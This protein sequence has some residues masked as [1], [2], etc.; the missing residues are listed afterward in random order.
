MKHFIDRIT[1][2][3]SSY[4][5]LVLASASTTFAGSMAWVSYARYGPDQFDMSFREVEGL[6]SL[7]LSAG[8]IGRLI[9]GLVN[10]HIGRKPVIIISSITGALCSFILIAIDTVLI[11][12]IAAALLG[13]LIGLAVPSY[14][15]VITDQVEEEG[16]MLGFAFPIIGSSISWFM[17]PM[18]GNFIFRRI[19]NWL[20]FLTISAVLFS[21]GLL[22]IIGL[23][24]TLPS[25]IEERKGRKLKQAFFGYWQV[26]LNKKFLLF[27]LVSALLVRNHDLVY[28]LLPTYILDATGIFSYSLYKFFKWG[29]VIVI[30]FQVIIAHIVSGRKPMRMM[31]V[32]GTILAAAMYLF[33][34][35]S[36]FPWFAVGVI[37]A[38]MAEMIVMP[39]TK[40][41]TAKFAP[42]AMRARYFALQ[43]IVFVIATQFRNPSNWIG[44]NISTQEVWVLSAA[45]CL[46]AVAG[47]VIFDAID[48][49]ADKAIHYLGNE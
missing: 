25:S 2:F 28:S 45:V 42:K 15:A 41:M 36:Q 12:K 20:S 31:A 48:Q 26:I 47:F 18:V 13:F 16:R 11:F 24:E 32:G 40:A 27:L 1:R 14:D 30:V 39:I 34:S 17:A 23:T 7:V 19:G 38:L 9:G 29:I 35:V 3:P 37:M 6:F 21:T 5:V 4:W 8:V 46:I 49:R 10:D 44:E 22:A 43:G 33:S